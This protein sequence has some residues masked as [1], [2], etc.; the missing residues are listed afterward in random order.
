MSD[1]G[2]QKQSKQSQTVCIV[3]P[4]ELLK[5]DDNDISIEEVFFFYL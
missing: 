3:E 2:F 4:E 1:N 5:G